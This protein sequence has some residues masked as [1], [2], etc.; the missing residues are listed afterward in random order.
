M[1]HRR[2]FTFVLLFTALANISPALACA[3]CFGK[4]DSAL[5]EGMNWGIFAMLGFIGIVLTGVASAAIFFIRRGA[6]FAAESQANPV[7]PTKV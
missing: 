6:R 7:S 2:L 1:K 4:S 5:A 3:T